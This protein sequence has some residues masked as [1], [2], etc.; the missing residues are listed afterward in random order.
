MW[1]NEQKVQFFLACMLAL[2]AGRPHFRLVVDLAI[3]L[4]LGLA[5]GGAELIGGE[6][7]VG[8][9][10]WSLWNELIS[11][12]RCCTAKTGFQVFSSSG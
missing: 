10:R 2:L 7:A 6:F 1:G 3:G 12:L 5:I 4:T 11:F 8:F 9:L